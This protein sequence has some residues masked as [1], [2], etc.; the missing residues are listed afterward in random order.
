MRLIEEKEKKLKK[1]KKENSELELQIDTLQKDVQ[2]QKREV[3]ALKITKE[4]KE[5]DFKS[6][7]LLLEEKLKNEN[8][9]T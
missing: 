5:M 1:I 3:E 2:N 9:N 8:D 6:E 7:V 4:Q